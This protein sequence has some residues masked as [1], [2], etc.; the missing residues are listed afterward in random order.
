MN[1]WAQS[2]RVTDALFAVQII[3]AVLSCSAQF[4]RSLVDVCGISIAVFGLSVLY[5]GFHV[6]LS[7][8]AHRA[9]ATRLTKQA[10]ITYCVWGTLTLAVIGAMIANGGYQWSVQDTTIVI[11][12]CMLTITLVQICFWKKKTI[13]D[14]QMKGLLAMTYKFTPN[15]FLAWKIFVEGGTGIPGLSIFIGHFTISIRVAQVFC[16]VR[17]AG[18]DRN[19]VWLT[20]SEVSNEVSWIIVTII[21]L[22]A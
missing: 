8:A 15:M 14:P 7:V 20:I 19:R 16:M 13:L 3:G 6:W 17:E 4:L 11:V 12:V 18:W 9:C 2:R 5:C 10:T 1:S 21:W 22:C